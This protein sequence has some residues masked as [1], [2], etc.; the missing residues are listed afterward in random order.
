MSVYPDALTGIFDL[1]CMLRDFKEQISLTVWRETIKACSHGSAV[2]CGDP[3]SL[4][5]QPDGI[6]HQPG[7]LETWTSHTWQLPTALRMKQ[8]LLYV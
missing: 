7:A 6:I 4:T 2:T 3:S 5:G 8:P 1:I